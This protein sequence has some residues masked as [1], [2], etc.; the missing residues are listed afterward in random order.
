MVAWIPVASSDDEKWYR[1]YFE[2]FSN[3]CFE[4]LI[5]KCHKNKGI[6]MTSRVLVQGIIIWKA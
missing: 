5:V 1:I 2:G 4:G 3:K 6:K